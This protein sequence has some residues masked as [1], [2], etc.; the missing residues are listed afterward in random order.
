MT[1]FVVIVDDAH[2]IDPQR[3]AVFAQPHQAE[4]HARDQVGA[5][6][7]RVVAAQDHVQYVSA[8]GDL[9]I[10]IYEVA[11]QGP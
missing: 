8:S 7:T 11:V 2:Q 1:V 10:N 3:P 9:F 4:Q 6:A 5:P